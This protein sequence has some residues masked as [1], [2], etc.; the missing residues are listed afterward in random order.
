M[1]KPYTKSAKG[2]YRRRWRPPPAKK[3]IGTKA[4]AATPKTRSQVMVF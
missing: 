4:V 3:F 1:P 2:V